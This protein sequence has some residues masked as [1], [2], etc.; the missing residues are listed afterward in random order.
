MRYYE[1][2]SNFET[3]T[4]TEEQITEMED[5]EQS[6]DD[7]IAATPM[8]TDAE[9]D[10]MYEQRRYLSE[11]VTYD[12]PRIALLNPK[13]RLTVRYKKPAGTA[14]P[15]LEVESEV[16][17]K[18]FSESEADSN[19][20][21]EADSDSESS[22]TSVDAH[23]LQETITSIPITMLSPEDEA[24]GWKS[25]NIKRR[26]SPVKH[27]N[28][29]SP[30]RLCCLGERCRNS[31]CDFAHNIHELKPGRCK[32]GSRCQYVRK[33]PSGYHNIKG[34]RPCA[35]LHPSEAIGD[36]AKRIQ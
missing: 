19:S 4:L 16:E 22:S 12:N 35:S 9:L 17:S 8:P 31:K 29:K 14:K 7:Y 18:I 26:I 6:Y 20:E 28:S 10:E 30:H 23:V 11:A 27:S 5:E 33:G 13:Y 25:V 34:S 1:E 3:D 32:Y 21:S 24:D 2:N 36:Y 15:I